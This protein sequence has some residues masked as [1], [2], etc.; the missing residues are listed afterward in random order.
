MKKIAILGSTGSVGRKALSVVEHLGEGYELCG[1]AVHSSTEELESQIRRWKP[2]VAGVIDPR[3]GAAL[4]AE[5]KGCGTEI[6]SGSEALSAV[7]ESSGADTLVV[8][9]TGREALRPTY[10]ALGRGLRVALASKEL[11]VMAGQALDHRM[12]E[13]SGHILPV[14]SEH[15]AVFQCLDQHPLKELRRVLLTG[16]G[17]PFRGRTRAELAD[18]TPEQAVAHPKW[19]MGKKISVDSATLMN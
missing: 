3:A 17:G 7:V 15:S 10:E 19:R 4:R 13:G 8:A 2:K 9:T 6:F 1:L 18:A 5:L 14:D 11:M 12:K 16:T